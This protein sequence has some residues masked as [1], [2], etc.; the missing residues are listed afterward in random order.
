M[1]DKKYFCVGYKKKGVFC[2]FY[3]IKN[4]LLWHKYVFLSPK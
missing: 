1:F 2:L 3:P 4:V